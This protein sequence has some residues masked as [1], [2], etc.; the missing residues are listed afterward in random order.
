MLCKANKP[1]NLIV[2]KDTVGQKAKTVA[3][4]LRGRYPCRITLSNNMSFDCKRNVVLT[5][6]PHFFK[7]TDVVKLLK[8]I[9]FL[10]PGFL[11]LYKNT[12]TNGFSVYNEYP[13]KFFIPMMYDY[14][15]DSQPNDIAVGYYNTQYRRTT[16]HFLEFVARNESRLNRIYV[17]GL[18]AS[19]KRC[20][21][22]I[23]KDLE[24]FVTVNKNLF[25]SNITHLVTPMSKSFLDPWPTVLEEGVRCNK[26]IIVLPVNR[27]WKDGI[28]DICSCIRYHTSFDTEMWY[29]NS[30]S[31]ILNFNL[32]AYYNSLFENNFEFVIDRNKFKSFNDF[33]THSDLLI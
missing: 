28:D 3:T 1:Y 20:I 27:N 18:N 25:F 6:V 4:Y 16:D 29:D 32:D 12:A 15:N 8:G 22:G 33:L 31:S 9:H 7:K 10:R 13:Y 17:L 21:H 24:V 19:I 11:S 23:N 14:K 30:D 5:Q 2:K 26:Q